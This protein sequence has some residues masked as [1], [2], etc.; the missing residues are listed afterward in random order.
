M[1]EDGRLIVDA[2]IYDKAAALSSRDN[3]VGR[4]FAFAPLAGLGITKDCA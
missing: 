3:P 1:R 2:E 4:R